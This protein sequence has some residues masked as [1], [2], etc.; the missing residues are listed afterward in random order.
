MS[1][2]GNETHG[3][4]IISPTSAELTTAQ[5]ELIPQ[6]KR[7]LL[8]PNAMTA[9]YNGTARTGDIR[10]INVDNEDSTIHV[11]INASAQGEKDGKRNFIKA[12]W[13]NTV[14]MTA[15]SVQYVENPHSPVDAFTSH[16][17]RDLPERTKEYW[18]T[19]GGIDYVVMGDVRA[20]D[21]EIKL[22]AKLLA[23][24]QVNDELTEKSFEHLKAKWDAIRII[25]ST[26]TEAHPKLSSE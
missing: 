25:D 16:V 26:A 6:I 10:F 18:Q 19:T 17:L 23:N 3:R 4:D 11:V 13:L 8:S 21:E 7:H 24:G 9:H 15:G 14:D 22:L 5:H 2:Q 1:E 20:S 12:K